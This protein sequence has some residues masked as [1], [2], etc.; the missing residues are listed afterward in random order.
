M[1][2]TRSSLTKQWTLVYHSLTTPIY[3]VHA[4]TS[5]MLN[6][7][8]GCAEAR[9]ASLATDAPHLI[10]TSLTLNFH[11]WSRFFRSAQKP[12]KPSYGRK[13]R[14]GTSRPAIAEVTKWSNDRNSRT[15]YAHHERTTSD[16]SY[17]FTQ[18]FFNHPISRAVIEPISVCFKLLGISASVSE[19]A[20]LPP[21]ISARCCGRRGCCCG[22]P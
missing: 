1:H 7:A 10:G 19:M 15:N 3:R 11:R 4:I 9:S 20:I 6:R 21:M 8:T 14:L 5:V 2:P 22:S 18:F 12:V 13:P 17:I 16:H